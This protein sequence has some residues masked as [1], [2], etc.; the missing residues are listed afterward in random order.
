GKSYRFITCQIACPKE[1]LIFVTP[2][3]IRPKASEFYLDCNATTPMLPQIAKAVEHVMEHVFGNPSS[4][5]ITGL[6]ARYILDN[7]RRLGRQLI[8]AGHGHFIFTSGA[9]EGIQTAVLSGLSAAKFDENRGA[10][11]WLLY[12]A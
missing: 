3:Q 11:R 7:T 5:H 2:V 4:S 1:S 10:K 12:G 8:G 6:Q 9:T